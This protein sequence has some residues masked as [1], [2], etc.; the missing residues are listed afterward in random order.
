LNNSV[1][2][3]NPAPSVRGRLD[4]FKDSIQQ[5]LWP[6]KRDKDELLGDRIPGKIDRTTQD[7]YLRV[8]DGYL[9]DALTK[10][11]WLARVLPSSITHKDGMIQIGPIPK[12]T[13]I[14]LLTNLTLLSE[15]RDPAERLRHDDKLFS[16][17][18]KMGTDLKNLP[19]NA[20][21]EERRKV[22]ANLVDPLLELSKCP[23]LIVNRGH[24]FGTDKFAGGESG[25]SDDDKHALIAF[26][27]RF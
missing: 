4:S 9:P 8:S 22:F 18:I 3:F 11:P 25:L 2:K 16:L 13:P 7:S 15:S 6:E 21:D 19:Q 12:G 24:Y 20:T 26:L 1:G 23:D 14:G 27:K 17:V 5:M 10:L